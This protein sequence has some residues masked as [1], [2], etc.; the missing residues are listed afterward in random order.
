MKIA[1][2][3]GEMYS[4]VNFSD[5]TEQAAE[6][7]KAYEGTGFRYLDFSFYDVMGEEH[8]FADDRWLTWVGRAADAAEKLGMKF[9]QAHSPNYN[10]MRRDADSSYHER[11]ILTTLRSIEACGR[12]GIPAIVVHTG[13]ADEV[14]Y[15]QD[16]DAYF[17]E[18]IEFI[19]KLY[20]A[21]EKWNVK[22]CIEN[23]A[24]GN[25]G[26][27]Y[28]Y[29]TAEDMNDFI[30]Y[31]G[32]PLLGCCWD[33]GHG[34]MRGADQHKELTTLSNNLTAVH[35]H[36]NMGSRDEHTAPF[37]G[38]I[39]MDSIM[40]GL[41]DANFGGYFTFESDSF[42]SFRN[43]HG[44]GRLERVPFDV[45]RASLALLYQIGKS[46]LEAYGIYEE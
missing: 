6:A 17:S 1:T 15:P 27:K 21:M 26:D 8:P 7:V 24:E 19:R 20:G 34:N 32:H 38:N 22:V 46:C 30:S 14:K 41:I 45:K 42:L 12:L 4:Y 31:A 5:M 28:F 18:N 43:V 25:M 29:M 2:T 3:I 44:S 13:W 11:G 33:V 35:I 39:D 9:V 23:S 37:F 10:P 36:D 16:K 40:T